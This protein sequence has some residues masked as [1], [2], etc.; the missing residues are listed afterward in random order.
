MLYVSSSKSVIAYMVT[1]KL[2]KYFDYFLPREGS[3]RNIR[4]TVVPLRAEEGI[5]AVGT[6]LE[7]RGGGLHEFLLAEDDDQ[8]GDEDDHHCEDHE[9]HPAEA[10]EGE[11]HVHAV[12]AG[13]EGRRHEQQ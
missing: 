12:E 7:P 10:V 9:P 4:V 8:N 2:A 3:S 6:R 13:D 11:L 1:A 5:F